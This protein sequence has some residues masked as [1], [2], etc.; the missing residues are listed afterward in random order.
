MCLRYWRTGPPV[1]ASVFAWLVF[2]TDLN[3]LFKLLAIAFCI[4][5]V[6]DL[7]FNIIPNSTPYVLA[8]GSITYNDGSLLLQIISQKQYYLVVKE[9]LQDV[10]AGNHGLAAEKAERIFKTGKVPRGL[11]IYCIG[12]YLEAKNYAKAAEIGD[13]LR[14]LPDVSAIEY[15]YLGT[16][17]FHQK[18]YQACLDNLDKALALN[19]E[20]YSAYGTRSL[21]HCFLGHLDEAI[22]DANTA[23]A[24]QP[25]NALLYSNRAYVFVLKELYVEA[26][27]DAT[28]A[29]KLDDGVSYAHNNRAYAKIKLG[30]LDA[31]LADVQRAIKLQPGGS[32]N[33]LVLGIYYWESG[34]AVSAKLQFLKAKELD[35][36]TYEL[37]KY[38]A[39]VEDVAYHVG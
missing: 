37:D 11:Y 14:E 34:D 9:M 39:L 31:G 12:C 8:D 13:L 38:L 22:A 20:D 4:S 36:D 6:V 26:V 5:G 15:A 10:K 7:F 30:L 3:D 29:I 33:Y 32:Y 19:S 27:A 16:I 17:D 28:Q 2:A 18:N 23:I 35:P 1:I 21:A 24:L 25:N